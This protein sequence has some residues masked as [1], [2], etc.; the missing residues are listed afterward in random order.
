MYMVYGRNLQGITVNGAFW[1]IADTFLAQGV[2]LW[3]EL[4]WLAWCYQKNMI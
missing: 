1:S 3:W 2:P 4:L